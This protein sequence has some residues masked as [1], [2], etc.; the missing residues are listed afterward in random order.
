MRQ[1]TLNF[2]AAELAE[3]EAGQPKTPAQLF[4]EFDAAN[5]DVYAA[6]RERSLRMAAHGFRRWSIEEIWNFLR[7]HRQC[8]TTGKPYSLN[9]N[10]KKP[11]VEKLVA[12]CPQLA[13]LFSRKTQKANRKAEP[14]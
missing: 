4:A 10:F 7:W 11:Y 5:P 14:R 8:V 1:P 9:N 12:E 3:I 13:N 6:I 2:D